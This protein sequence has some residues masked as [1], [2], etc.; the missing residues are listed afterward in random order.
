MNE[1]TKAK[2]E[3][4]QTLAL[5]HAVEEMDAAHALTLA[6]KEDRGDRSWL[7]GMCGKSLGVA[8]R[9]EQYLALKERGA[10]FNG[11]SEGD[12]AKAEAAF[13]RRAEAQIAQIMG[14]ARPS[15]KHDKHGA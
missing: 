6:T 8:L 9:V 2:L 13:V 7:T 4:L 12:A 15:F 10:E 5:A 3:R 14:R 11:Q 1:D